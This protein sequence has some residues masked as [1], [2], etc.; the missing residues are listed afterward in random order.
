V[1]AGAN[2]R[3]LR[4]WIKSGRLPAV[5]DDGQYRILITDLERASHIPPGEYRTPDTDNPDTPDTDD[6]NA[7]TADMPGPGTMSGVDLTPLAE[8]IERQARELA[9][10]REAAA[11]WQIRARQAEARLEAL[12]A[13]ETQAEPGRDETEQKPEPSTIAPGSSQSDRTQA[14]GIQ[15]LWDWLRGRG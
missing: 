10:M 14:T 4:R 5:K 2:E 9:E 15:R 1:W 8:L 13:G 3:T 7:R 12:E 11:V 6:V